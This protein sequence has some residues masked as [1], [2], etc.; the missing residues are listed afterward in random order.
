MSIRNGLIVLRMNNEV[1]Q[2]HWPG[3]ISGKGLSEWAPQKYLQT[4]S[5]S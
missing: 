5:S 4:M 2:E 1:D 3:G